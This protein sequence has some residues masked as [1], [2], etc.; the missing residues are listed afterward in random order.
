MPDD[1]LVAPWTVEQVQHLNWQQRSG[2]VHPYTCGQCR[3]NLGIYYLIEGGRLRRASDEE[4]GE[5][6]AEA[7]AAL[8]TDDP[9]AHLLGMRENYVVLDR[10]LVATVN[11]WI[12]PTCDYTQN[13]A[14]P[15]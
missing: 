15:I 10:E 6:T 7:R 1:M 4:W 5:A 11:G 8:E 12:C 2:N 14:H 13:W 9:I 3:D